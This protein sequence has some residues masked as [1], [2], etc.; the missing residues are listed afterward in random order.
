MSQS[1]LPIKGMPDLASPE[2]EVWQYIES[3]AREVLQ[4]YGLKEVRTPIVERLETFVRAVG[5]TTDI[6]QKEMYAFK[7][8][9]TT[10]A[11]RPEGTAGILRY[12]AGAGPDAADARVYY[13]GPMFR[14][15]RMQKGRYRQFSQ[16]GVEIIGAANPLADVEVMDLQRSLL[17]TW[18]VKDAVFE[19]NTRGM[20]EDMEAVRLGLREQ[21]E[22]RSDQLCE[23]CQRRLEVNILRVLD[24]KRETCRVVTQSLPPMTDFMSEE[25]RAYLEAVETG[26]EQL[27][28]PF[29][30]NPL[31]VRGLDYYVNTVWEITS[32]ALGAQNAV[33][34][35]GRYQ[36]DVGDRLI[37]GV[38]FAIGLNRVGMILAEQDPGLMKRLRPPVASLVGLGDEAFNHNLLLVQQL[39]NA[40]IPCIMALE[41]KGMKAQMKL[42]NRKGSAFAVIRGETELAEG[43]CQVKE[44][45]TGEQVEVPLDDLSDYLR[46]GM[47][48]NG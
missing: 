12:A 26:L 14:A 10:L 28:I 7:R 15:E 13:M 44:M 31:L 9:D 4:R 46:K 41:P 24:C 42:A 40:G 19:I 25:S 20:P 33:A 8:G 6:V 45:E 34:G 39:R 11:L 22:P 35:G 16:L 5:D 1:Y 3:T 32:S 36:M 47:K 48:L 30:R 29:I 38:G 23:D 21:L 18:G 27:S 43:N 17:E 2:V 37:D